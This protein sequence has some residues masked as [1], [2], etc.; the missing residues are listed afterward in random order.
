MNKTIKMY[1]LKNHRGKYYK[2]RAKP[3]EMFSV[4]VCVHWVRD[5]YRARKFDTSDEAAT[6]GS[7]M[8]N[9]FPDMAFKVEERLEVVKVCPIKKPINSKT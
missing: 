1:Y 7:L 3:G 6:C 5:R 2:F 4:H 8:M 9:Y